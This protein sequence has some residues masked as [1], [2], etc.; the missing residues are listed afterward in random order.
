M[1]KK[2]TLLLTFTACA[3]LY[4]Q[5]LA[6]GG[7]WAPY[8]P[9]SL[10]NGTPS[11]KIDLITFDKG[12]SYDLFNDKELQPLIRD[13][14]LKGNMRKKRQRSAKRRQSEQEAVPVLNIQRLH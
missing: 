13:I 6:C 5:V 9:P 1:N 10:D 4:G 12:V 8:V 11:Q 7:G 2:V 14:L 3:L